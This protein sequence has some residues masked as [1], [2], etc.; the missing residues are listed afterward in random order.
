MRTYYFY[1]VPLTG[2]VYL[3][4]T[5]ATE[6]EIKR[7]FPDASIYDDKVIIFRRPPVEAVEA[8]EDIDKHHRKVIR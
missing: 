5:E 2:Q 8:A 4:K 1:A 3:G 7:V 6:A